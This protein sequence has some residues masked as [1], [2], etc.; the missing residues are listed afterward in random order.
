MKNLI[1]ISTILIVFSSCIVQ[2]KQ[3][4]Y[5]I[6]D[7]YFPY[8]EF[9]TE[10]T[11]CFQNVND[12]ADKVYW[13]MKTKTSGNDTL[14]ITKLLN[15][16]GENIEY[17]V[18]KIDKYGSILIEH[19]LYFDE[20]VDTC[21]IIDTEVFNWNMRIGENLIWKVD[22]K[23]T[24][25]SRI[26]EFSKNRTLTEYDSTNNT[27]KFN[28]KMKFQAL[29]SSDT[30]EYSLEFE[31]TK[32]IGATYYKVFVENEETKEYSLIRK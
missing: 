22:F 24:G 9:N 10:K 29:G 15:A 32:N 27:I 17:L 23:E 11:Y 3:Q 6:K 21:R 19:I 1:F 26:I 28:D 5:F 2:D 20:I 14:F 7:Y 18:E 12:T 31:Y 16:K 4:K 30:Y 13:V 8:N 25:S